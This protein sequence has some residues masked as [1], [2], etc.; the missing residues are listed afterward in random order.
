MKYIAIIS[1]MFFSV[2]C[3]HIPVPKKSSD[4]IVRSSL[5]IEPEAVSTEAPV[6][7]IKKEETDILAEPKA[8]LP[9]KMMVSAEDHVQNGITL[10]LRDQVIEAEAELHAALRKNPGSIDAVNLVHQINTDADVYFAGESFFLYEIQ[11]GDTL[12]IVAQK[13]LNDPLKFY[14]LAK[15]NDISN[16]VEL[17]AGR[18]IKVPGK[19]SWETESNNKQPEEAKDVKK[20]SQY[21][22]AQK[23]Y[24]LGSYQEA[25]DILEKS[26]KQ[27]PHDI[28][29]RDLLVLTYTRYA[30]TLTEKADLLEAQT[31]LEKALSMQPKNA[32]LQ[33][34]LDELEKRR[35][36]D[37][38]YQIGISALHAGN[39][40]KA[41]S[42]FEKTLKLQPNHTLA[43]KQ[44]V[45]IK[46]D[47]INSYHK[48]ALQLFTKQKLLE[49][50]ENWD[51][52]LEIDPS[53]ELARLYRARALEL[54]ERLNNLEAN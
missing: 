8:E 38:F 29:S 43:R 2:S 3:G 22:I 44:I 6:V 27:D 47:V 15:Y 37:Q 46:S 14:I 26:T 40:D 18:L 45:S 25:I 19:K 13:Y 28:E 53:H 35:Q 41:F 5:Q 42:Y 9:Q 50:V 34:Q 4:S 21:E 54:Q 24:E 16:S 51:H 1:I 31:I 52:V 32:K 49:A 33:R 30:E 39:E 36:A 20:S 7:S 10:L 12:S 17:N 23:Y 11:Q 48:K